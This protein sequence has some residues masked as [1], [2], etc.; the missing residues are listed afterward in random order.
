MILAWS[1]GATNKRERGT[2][3]ESPR[4]CGYESP[5]GGPC[6]LPKGHKPA[7]L[8][9]DGL[10]RHDSNQ[11]QIPADRPGYLNYGPR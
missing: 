10:K 11:L 3:N 8:H 7:R 4:L 6:I 9:D 5:F 1:I 2:M